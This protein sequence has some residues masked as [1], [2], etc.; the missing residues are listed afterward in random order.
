MSILQVRLS[1][2][3]L[4][5]LWQPVQVLEPD[6]ALCLNSHFAIAEYMAIKNWANHLTNQSPFHVSFPWSLHQI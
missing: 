1:E 4:A 3:K 5:P 6:K 2:I